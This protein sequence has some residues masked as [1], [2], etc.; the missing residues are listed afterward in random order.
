M[1]PPGVRPTLD[2][3]VAYY[4]SGTMVSGGGAITRPHTST[5]YVRSRVAP[6]RRRSRGRTTVSS[7]SSSSKK[8]GSS[9]P[10]RPQSS[11]QMGRSRTGGFGS[12]AIGGGGGGGGAGMQRPASA[13]ASAGQSSS[14]GMARSA[15]LELQLRLKELSF[16]ANPHGLLSL[17]GD[18]AAESGAMAPVLL[19]LQ[20]QMVE[21]VLSEELTSARGPEERGNSVFSTGGGGGGGGGGGNNNYSDYNNNYVGDGDGGDDRML[22]SGGGGS[23]GGGSSGGSGG[24]SASSNPWGDLT[25]GRTSGGGGGSGGGGRDRGVRRVPFIDLVLRLKEDREDAQRDCLRLEEECAALR[26]WKEDA[27]NELEMLRA[28]VTS[29]AVDLRGRDA[30]AESLQRKLELEKLDA[31]KMKVRENGD[32]IGSRGRGGKE[33]SA[34]TSARGVL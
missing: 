3:Q 15:V 10:P 18:V 27:S 32:R 21:F 14:V 12:G 19:G 31:T 33:A 24:S 2:S 16:P 17:L 26:E 20:D 28:K 22:M 13:L 6:A 11:Q 1:A 5:G 30:D 23:G 25:T 8:K 34:G 29:T 4:T 9:R 7:S